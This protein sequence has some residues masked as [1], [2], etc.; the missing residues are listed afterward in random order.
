MLA[1]TGLGLSVCVCLPPAGAAD[2]PVG[3]MEEEVPAVQETSIKRLVVGPLDILLHSSA[4]H[5]VLKMVTCAMD[6]EYEPYCKP[7]RGQTSHCPLKQSS[8]TP[9]SAHL[10]LSSPA[11][12][13]SRDCKSLHLTAPHHIVI[14]LHN[15]SFN[16]ELY[17]KAVTFWSARPR[18]SQ[19]PLLVISPCTAIDE[20]IAGML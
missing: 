12:P 8:S 11:L 7:Q 19:T 20:L 15:T 6:H 13:A 2:F 9:L 18:S 5:R 1:L 10:P 14:S 3:S 4:V 16:T 17:M